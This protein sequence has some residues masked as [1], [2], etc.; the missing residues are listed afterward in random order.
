MRER[1]ESAPDSRSEL[2]R[3]RLRATGRRLELAVQES[4]RAGM[5][6]ISTVIAASSDQIR[7][8]LDAPALPATCRVESM[9]GR[10]EQALAVWISLK[11]F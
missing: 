1:A 4:E 7:S 8:L 10:A 3:S 6:H 11:A 5:L 9:I 2:L